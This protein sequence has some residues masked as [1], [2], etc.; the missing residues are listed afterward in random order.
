MRAAFI[1]SNP[2]PA[3]AALAMLGKVQNV[4][5]SPLVPLADDKAGAIRSALATAGVKS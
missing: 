1:E 2:L 5:R 4:L 3:K